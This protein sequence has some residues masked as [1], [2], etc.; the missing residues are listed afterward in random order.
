MGSKFSRFNDEEMYVIK[1]SLMDSSFK[2]HMEDTYE[3]SHRTIH[4]DLMNEAVEEI[5]NR[6]EVNSTDP[7]RLL[8]CPFCGAEMEEYRGNCGRNHM[9][10]PKTRKMFRHP[11]SE[12]ET[13]CL[14]HKYRSP[15]NRSR[16]LRWNRRE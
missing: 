2:F 9:G 15:A 4:K 12:G 11:Q 1:R 13:K 6:K 8:P 7:L 14:M 10:W 16:I 3:D 5:K